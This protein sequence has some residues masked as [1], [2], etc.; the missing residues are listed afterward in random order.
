MSYKLPE[1]T[2]EELSAIADA[3]IKQ[4]ADQKIVTKFLEERRAMRAQRRAFE[5]LYDK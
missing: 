5:V 1:L 3:A 4:V 2:Q